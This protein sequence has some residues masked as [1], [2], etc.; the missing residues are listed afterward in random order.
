MVE[1][2]GAVMQ[3]IRSELGRLPSCAHARPEV[4]KFLIRDIGLFLGL[5]FL[6][7]PLGASDFFYQ[8]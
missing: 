2:G 3:K 8:N 5:T 7:W 1:L 4:L 6:S